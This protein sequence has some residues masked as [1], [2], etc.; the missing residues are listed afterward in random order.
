M[1][2]TEQNFEQNA[3]QAPS[4]EPERREFSR[5]PSEEGKMKKLIISVV[6]LV[7]IAVGAAFAVSHFNSS[8]SEEGAVNPDDRVAVVGDTVITRGELDERVEQFTLLSG[9]PSFQ[10]EDQEGVEREVLEQMIRE[11]LLLDAADEEGIQVSEEEVDEEFNIILE[12]FPDRSVLEAQLE[13]LQ[14]TEEQL[15]SDLKN[16]LIIDKYFGKI[17]EDRGIEVTEEEMRA[18]FDQINTEE[19]AGLVY[20][21]IKDQIASHLRSEKIS[22]IVDE[23]VEE[24]RERAGVEVLL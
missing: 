17:A 12:Q 15:R 24:L 5:G 14:M 13:E 3:Q 22:E 4:Q 21:E 18:F 8:P 20:E 7:V 2:D 6:V 19:E 9:D 11:I 1:A 23:V 10:G 16:Q